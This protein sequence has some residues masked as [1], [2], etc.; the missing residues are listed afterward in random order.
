MS[1][2]TGFD[3]VRLAMPPR[4]EADAVA[5]YEGV[6]GLP[7]IPTPAALAGRGRWWFGDGT[8][9]IHLAEEEGFEA[10][11]QAYP[12]LAVADLH[13]LTADLR[14]AGIEVTDGPV[15]DGVERA[16]VEDP[17]GNRLELVA[18]AD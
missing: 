10:A 5:F 3:H 15:L 13:A 16:V 18:R 12:A 8:V 6:L 1:R 11:R 9:E 4:R 14:A 2:L 17:F 7:R